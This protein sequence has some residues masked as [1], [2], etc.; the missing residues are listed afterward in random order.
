MRYRFIAAKKACFPVRLLCRILQ[1][2]R[3]GYYGWRNRPISARDQEKRHLEVKIRSLHRA[4]RRI[5]GSPRIFNA[6]RDSGET[7]RLST[8]WL[9]SCAKRECV[10]RRCA[11]SR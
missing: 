3:S 2:S 7:C 5:Y 4:S 9:A 11:S 1:V 6:L 8:A 10:P